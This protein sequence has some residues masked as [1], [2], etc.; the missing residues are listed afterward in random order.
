[1]SGA[2][3]LA[4][5][6]LVMGGIDKYQRV[7]KPFKRYKHFASDARTFHAKFRIQKHLYR[8]RI[9]EIL[10]LAVNDDTAD[11]MLSDVEH[12]SWYSIS[13]DRDLRQELGSSYSAIQDAVEVIGMELADIVTVSDRLDLIL[14]EDPKVSLATRSR[15]RRLISTACSRSRQA[16][17]G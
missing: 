4:I 7:A 12:E 14:N 1:M 3:A 11:A 9:R 10:R 5:L 15:S 16:V 2:E 6:P 8:A 13:V 17:A